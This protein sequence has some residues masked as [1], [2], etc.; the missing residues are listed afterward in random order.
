LNRW[1][2]L[3]LTMALAGACDGSTE[4]AGSGASTSPSSASVTERDEAIW[5]SASTAK[6]LDDPLGDSIPQT[7]PFL[8]TVAYGVG[9]ARR[10]PTADTW[11]RCGA[12]LS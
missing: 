8:D 12:T 5:S 4:S 3:L 1:I 7:V 10:D 2:L 11:T 9:V 6:M